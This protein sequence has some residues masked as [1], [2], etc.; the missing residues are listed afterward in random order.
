MALF[1]SGAVYTYV[2]SSLLAN[3]PRFTVSRPTRVALGGQTIEIRELCWVH[4][5]IEGLKFDTDA[6]PVKEIGM[7]EGHDLDAIIGV[8]TMERYEILLNPRAGTL[9]LRG[10]ERGELTEF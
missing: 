9:D 3:A 1:D 4:G 8:L 5:S 7:V 2:R 6:V 10:L